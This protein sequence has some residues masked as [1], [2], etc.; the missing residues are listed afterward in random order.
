ALGGKKDNSFLVE[1]GIDLSWME[2]NEI[3]TEFEYD[4]VFMKRLHPGK[5]IYDIIEIWGEVVKQKADA[6]LAIMGEGSED[7]RN[8]ILSRMKELEIEDNI[9]LIGPVYDIDEKLK[10]LRSSKVFVL[11][12]HEENWAIVIGEA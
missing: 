9:D 4:A 2:E 11:P 10:I 1:C 8:R 6:R 12:S 3:P 5:G 7:V